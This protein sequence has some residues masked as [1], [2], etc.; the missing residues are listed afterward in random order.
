MIEEDTLAELAQSIKEQ[1]VLQPIIVTQREGKYQL[2]CGERR[3]RASRL[4]G[5]EKIPAIVKEAAGEKV[6]EMALVENL[7]REDL[8]ALEEAQAYAKL[9]GGRGLTQEDLASRVGKSR[10]AVANALR[11]LSLPREV[12]DLIV[13]RV[14]TGGHA[15]AIVPL[16]SPEHQRV[17]AQRVV[18][19]NLSVRQTEE[20]AQN[21]LTGKRRAK[22][23]RR[24][25]PYVQDLERKLEHKLATQVRLFHGKNNHGRIEVRYFSLD[26][27]DRILQTLGVEKS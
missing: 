24:L 27:L 9:V 26:D 3:L 14:I 6:L 13:N 21:M 5:L 4:A 7:Q 12:Q 11:L 1:G 10:S 2:I 16:P 20:I 17:L 22:R 15:K 8:N 18:K 25:D 19:E 23:L